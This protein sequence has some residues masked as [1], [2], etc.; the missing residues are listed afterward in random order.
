[1]DLSCFQEQCFDDLSLANKL[2]NDF[3]ETAYA[4]VAQLESGLSRCDLQELARRAHALQGVAGLLG[5]VPLW[6]ITTQLEVAAMAENL[7]LIRLRV[8]Q[9]RQQIRRPLEVIPDTLA[10][11]QGGSH[12][13]L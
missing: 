3:A 9:V 8:R 5:A 7:T 10:A 4:R 2:L 13:H 11:F 6:N 12:S 1:L